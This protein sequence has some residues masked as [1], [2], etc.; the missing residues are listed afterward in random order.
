MNKQ[1]ILGGSGAIGGHLKKYL[2]DRGSTVEDFDIV[3]GI[4]FDLRECLL[5]DLKRY[6]K[7]YFLAWDV[8]GAKYIT[9][10]SS[11]YDQLKSN[12]RIIVNTFPQIIDS[13]VPFLF[14]SSQLAGVDESPYSITKLLGEKFSL[15]SSISRVVRQWNVYGVSEK[16]GL[17]S[18][19]I[20]DMITSAKSFD[21]IRLLTDGSELRQF[22]HINDVCEAYERVFELP[23]DIYQVSSGEWISIFEV[24]SILGKI[25]K[26]EVKR[27]LE[28]G[29]SPKVNIGKPISNWTPK[30]TL[31]DGLAAL[32][33][34]YEQ[35][36]K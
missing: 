3:N 5:G 2:Q 22:V 19:V 12:T 16:Y 9:D 26:V 21:E 8:G 24:A 32:V 23:S 11:H 4:Q 31:H 33:A 27:G 6:S 18:H 10:K 14:V 13:K 20:S 28:K 7:I 30:V 35:S 25:L 34:N 36:K 15:Q 29:N 1:L 17:K